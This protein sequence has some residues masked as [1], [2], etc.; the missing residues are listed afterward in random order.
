[1]RGIGPFPGG[2][3]A[4]RPEH[5]TG[6]GFQLDIVAGNPFS[7]DGCS[8]VDQD[9]G[10]LD[11]GRPRTDLLKPVIPDLHTALVPLVRCGNPASIWQIQYG[12]LPSEIAGM[13]R[14]RREE[15]ADTAP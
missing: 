10:M 8:I 4:G 3:E 12:S 5:H 2:V 14:R 11:G 6:K 9:S 15:T 7:T 13:L 1:M